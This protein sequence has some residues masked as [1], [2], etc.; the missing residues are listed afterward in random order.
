MTYTPTIGLEIHAELLT[1]SKLFC[2]CKNDPNTEEV[3]YYICPVCMGYPGAL[4]Y[5]N[6]KA[7]ENVLRIGVAL[8]GTTADFTEFDRKHY[9]YPDIPKGYQISQYAYPL[10]SGGEL[11]GVPIERIHLEEDTAKSSH[12]AHTDSSVIDFNRAGVPLMELV[13]KP[14]IKSAEQAKKFAETLQ[15]T[16]RYLGVS[17]ARMEWGEMRVEVNISISDT[18]VLGVKVEI[19]NLNSFKAVVDAIEYETKRQTEIISSGGVVDQETRGWNENVGKTISQ[20]SKETSAEYRYMPEPDIPKLYITKVP[21]WSVDELKKSIPELPERKCI[22][23]KQEYGLSSKQAET[24]IRNKMLCDLFDAT[25]ERLKTKEKVQLAGNY[26][27][28][29]VVGHI[30]KSGESVLAHLDDSNLSSLIDMISSNEISSRGAKNILAILVK[31]GGDSRE[32]AE[33]ENLFQQSDEAVLLKIIEKAIAENEKVVNDYRNGSVGAL[34]FFVGI[35][36]R[37]TKGA[38]NPTKVQEILKATI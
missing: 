11:T 32:I 6:K 23:Y 20:R 9:F 24:L 38:A 21:Q 3:N 8:Q 1:E 28:S 33:R 2:G 5:I 35:V 19:K 30:E 26:L 14:T 29:D 22:R 15:N 27:T 31:G 36:M 18:D 10:I 7:I 17:K 37:E 34:Q 12:N 25:A 4:P 16:L 13:T